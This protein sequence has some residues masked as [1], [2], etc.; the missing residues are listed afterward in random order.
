M[1]RVIVTAYKEFE[2]FCV[3]QYS[4]HQP[5]LSYNIAVKAELTDI[6]EIIDLC[7]RAILRDSK[8][9]DFIS[10]IN[11]SIYIE[12]RIV[13]D[14]LNL[15]SFFANFTEDMKS[16]LH[17]SELHLNI[18]LFGTQSVEILNIFQYRIREELSQIFLAVTH[19]TS[20]PKYNTNNVVIVDK[21]QGGYNECIKQ[22]TNDFAKK[23]KVFIFNIKF[24]NDAFDMTLL[25]K[26]MLICS[27]YKDHCKGFVIN[28]ANG[29]LYRVRAFVVNIL[30]EKIFVIYGDSLIEPS[31]NS[32]GKLPP[33]VYVE[34]AAD[35]MFFQRPLK[36]EVWRKL[37]TE[38]VDHGG[39]SVQE[40]I[41]PD[42]FRTDGEC[43]AKFWPYL[44][45]CQKFLFE[46]F[47]DNASKA[48]TQLRKAAY[49][50][51]EFYDIYV[52]KIPFLALFVFAIYD[53]FYRSNLLWRFKKDCG[54][55]N[56]HLSIEDFVLS[57]QGAQDSKIFKRYKELKSDYDMKNLVTEYDIDS[58]GELHIVL[59]K[60]IAAEI[61]ECISISEGL[62]QILENAVIHARSGLLSLRVYSRAKGLDT[63]TAKKESHIKYL[64]SSYKV[65][66]FNYKNA[67]FYLEVQL[68]DLSDKSIPQK[69]IENVEKDK[70]RFKALLKNLS[71]TEEQFDNIKKHINTAFFFT[72]GV[73]TVISPS[74][75]GAGP[76]KVKVMEDLYKFR[77]AFYRID[78]NLVHHYGLEI[79]NSIITS[80]GGIFSVCGYNEAYDNL[81]DIFGKVY[82]DAAKFVIKYDGTAY[83]QMTQYIKNQFDNMRK[84]DI[85]NV[86]TII[87]RDKDLPGTTYRILLPLDHTDVVSYNFSESFEEDSTDMDSEWMPVY[88]NETVNLNIVKDIK[89]KQKNINQFHEFLKH[90]FYTALD[91]AGEADK[92]KLVMCLNIPEIQK[93]TDSERKENGD[94]FEELIKGVLLFAL[95]TLRGGKADILPIAIVNL[96]SFQLIEAA[97]L[98]SIYYAKRSSESGDIF[99]KMPVYL[100][101]MNESKE[102]IFA[103]KDV[104]EVQNRIIK[105]AMKNGTMF[106]ELATIAD[107]LKRVSK[108]EVTDGE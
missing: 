18:L 74:D 13:E 80:R 17:K 68:S 78:K 88:I 65:Q 95:E 57:K 33:A 77:Q 101:C 24:A 83:A 63:E 34:N 45:L 75:K 21:L 90:K 44:R 106:D 59:H 99:D 19:K 9:G 89:D 94:H 40:V 51:D 47:D 52:S 100:K 39:K 20:F 28:V 3:E 70:E 27:K 102:V 60:T 87:Q 72:D 85:N 104:N 49:S 86:R 58:S 79:F 6:K 56:Y 64:N 73:G 38:H 67:D 7:S 25:H 61:F 29:G 84:D 96:N 41:G 12:V 22:L 4:R 69:F 32:V 37:Y 55:K 26:C 23:D 46:D 2:R 91:K 62:L 43:E 76:E 97:R 93:V 30:C 36:K 16:V 35:L 5:D 42:A 53:N 66:Y 1:G 92:T 15:K 82:E 14:L 81:D 108:K 10:A 107:I 54:R 98:I 11:L 103:G 48:Y 105:T 50:C 71:W 8:H 31:I